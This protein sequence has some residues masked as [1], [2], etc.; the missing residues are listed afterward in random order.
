M[1]ETQTRPPRRELGSEYRTLELELV[2]TS[3]CITHARTVYYVLNFLFFIPCAISCEREQWMWNVKRRRRITALMMTHE[4]WH[5]AEIFLL[6]PFFFF[7]LGISSYSSCCPFQIPC[8]YTVLF[9]VKLHLGLDAS[10]HFSR[11]ACEWKA[12]NML[13]I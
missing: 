1:P 9:T 12:L 11:R 4:D 6:L 13:C 3:L 8:F 7:W 10:K 2:P 5:P